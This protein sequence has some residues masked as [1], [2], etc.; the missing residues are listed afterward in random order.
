MGTNQGNPVQVKSWTWTQPLCQMLLD[1]D[2][3]ELWLGKEDN[4]PW[5]GRKVALRIRR[6]LLACHVCLALLESPCQCC[7]RKGITSQQSFPAD[8]ATEFPPC[9]HTSTVCPPKHKNHITALAVS[10]T[11]TTCQ[12]PIPR[13]DPSAR[14]RL[15]GSIYTSCFQCLGSLETT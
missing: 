13:K 11:A 7:G 9:D 3:S 12:Y 6:T 10:V 14:R 2:E 8:S 4:L 15:Q 5:E 1:A